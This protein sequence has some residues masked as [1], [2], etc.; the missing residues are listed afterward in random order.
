LKE[1][2]QKKNRHIGSNPISN[3]YDWDM[4]TFLSWK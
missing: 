4:T 3:K 1:I 2:Y